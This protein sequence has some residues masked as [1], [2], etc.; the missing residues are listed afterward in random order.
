M[1]DAEH[2]LHPRRGR[3]AGRGMDARAVD[4]DVDARAPLQQDAGSG[5]DRREVAEVRGDDVDAYAVASDDVV[6]IGTAF[7]GLRYTMTM[8][9]PR[10]ARRWTA[11]S[12]TPEVEPATTHTLPR[13]DASVVFWTARRLAR[14]CSCSGSSRFIVTSR[15]APP[16]PVHEPRYGPLKKGIPLKMSPQRS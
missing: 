8:S 11:A 14:N 13:I 9:A 16:T 2:G 4:E 1:V 3:G 5:A 6:R 7:P 15:P 12:P 10:R